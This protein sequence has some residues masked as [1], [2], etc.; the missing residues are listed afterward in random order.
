MIGEKM[1]AALNEQIKI[2][3]DSSSGYLAMSAW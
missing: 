2:E 3:A 1:T